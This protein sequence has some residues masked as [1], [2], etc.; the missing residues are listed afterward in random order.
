MFC[1][2]GLPLWNIERNVNTGVLSEELLYNEMA[3]C[4]LVHGRLCNGMHDFGEKACCVVGPVALEVQHTVGWH[5]CLAGGYPAFRFQRS[6]S[7]LRL[8]T[9]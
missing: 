2:Q 5:A 4:E 8:C 9:H 6:L 7:S 1:R 3:D